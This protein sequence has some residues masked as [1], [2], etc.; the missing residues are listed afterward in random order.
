MPTARDVLTNK[1]RQDVHTVTPETSVQDAC[2]L[3]RQ[4]RIGCLVVGDGKSIEGIISERD[5]INR[6]VADHLDSADTKVKDVM[7][8]EVIFVK[9]DRDI[10]EV[11][12]IMRQQ[13]IRHL[14]VADE[15]GLRGLISV[16]DVLGYHCH[17]DR[18]MV[19]YLQD[20]VY[21]RH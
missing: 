7:T 20:Y 19:E 12:A 11:E 3:M 10:T 17:T 5:V 9:P 1:E 15:T 4:H 8:T 18:Q 2:K 21:G 6:V 14:P 13:R 16:G